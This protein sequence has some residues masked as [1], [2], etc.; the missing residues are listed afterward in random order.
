MQVCVMI[1]T[2]TLELSVTV[3][4]SVTGGTAVGKGEVQHGALQSHSITLQKQTFLV[5]WMSPS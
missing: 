1:Q 4:V 5:S 3:P 2:G